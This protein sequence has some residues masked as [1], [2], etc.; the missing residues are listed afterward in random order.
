M[1]KENICAFLH[2]STSD[3]VVF[4]DSCLPLC[5]DRLPVMSAS[6]LL[7]HGSRTVNLWIEAGGGG[8]VRSEYSKVDVDG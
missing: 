7:L 1:E 3:A 4:G 6:L 2:G 8:T 5:S